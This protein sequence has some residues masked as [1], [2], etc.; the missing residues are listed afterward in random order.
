MKVNRDKDINNKDNLKYKN[1]G[2]NIF[3]KED[4]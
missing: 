3:N 4:K 1:V 2:N